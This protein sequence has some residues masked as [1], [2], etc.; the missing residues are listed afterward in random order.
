MWFL[1]FESAVELECVDPVNVTGVDS[2]ALPYTECAYSLGV[3]GVVIPHPGDF[4]GGL[5]LSSGCRVVE[6]A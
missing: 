5:Y 2:A 6:V 1:I 4:I 3:N